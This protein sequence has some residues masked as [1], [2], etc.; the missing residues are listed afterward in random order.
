[1]IPKDELCM[2]SGR[3]RSRGTLVVVTD[4]PPGTVLQKSSCILAVFVLHL[5]AS[6]LK[7]IIPPKHFGFWVLF[8]FGLVLRF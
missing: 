8:F 2:F 1:M 4:P 6:L 7:Y 3:R 5:N